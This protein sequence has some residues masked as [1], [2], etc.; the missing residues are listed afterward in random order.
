MKHSKLLDRDID[1][2]EGRIR[3]AY[4]KGKISEQAYMNL[5]NK[6]SIIYEQIYKNKL[7]LLNGNG[8]QFKKIKNEITDAYAEGKIT[9]AALQAFTREDFKLQR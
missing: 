9:E 3:R 8:I 7:G 6:I 2:L 5:K 1:D 4:E